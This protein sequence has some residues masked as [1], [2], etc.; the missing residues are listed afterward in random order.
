MAASSYPLPEGKGQHKNMA[1]GVANDADV[2]PASIAVRT[3]QRA[4]QRVVVTSCAGA[5]EE[6]S[7]HSQ[8]G[9]EGICPLSITTVT[10][11]KRRSCALGC[12]VTRLQATAAR[13][14]ECVEARR[15]DTLFPQCNFVTFCSE[16]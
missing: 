16:S 6:H 3:S 10:P 9:S 5:S 1:I 7:G 11:C 8:G 13:V 14:S 2:S 15:C 12:S 4:Q